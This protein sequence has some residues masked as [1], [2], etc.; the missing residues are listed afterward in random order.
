MGMWGCH[1]PKHF[2]ICKKVAQKLAK[3]QESWL[4]YFCDFFILE[5]IVGQLVKTHHPL[6]DSV[7]VHH[8]T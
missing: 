8:C 5:T 7:L 6:M 3:L 1:T 2:Q 4:Q